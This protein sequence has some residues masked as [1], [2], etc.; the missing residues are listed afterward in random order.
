MELN[1]DHFEKSLKSILDQAFVLSE[2]YT[3]I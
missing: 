3:N 2:Q 1:V